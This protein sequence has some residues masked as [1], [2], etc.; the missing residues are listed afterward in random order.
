MDHC[1]GRFR[2]LWK[3]MQIT[4]NANV[5]I[6]VHTLHLFFDKSS[7]LVEHCHSLYGAAVEMYLQRETL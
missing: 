6:E 4:I 2:Q 1:G 5:F 3:E 7:F